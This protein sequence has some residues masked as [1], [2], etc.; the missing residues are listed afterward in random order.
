VLASR[1]IRLDTENTRLAQLLTDLGCPPESGQEGKTEKKPDV[2]S[3][4]TAPNR[5][6]LL[7]YLTNLDDPVHA[8]E[9]AAALLRFGPQITDMLIPLLYQGPHNR[10]AWIAVLLY[11]LNDPR[12]TKPLSDLLETSETGLREL[13]WDIRLRFREWRRSTVSSSVA[14]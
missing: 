13:I 7:T 4:S 9:A 14:Q 5:S 10:R 8:M 6:D 2:I 12:A 11:E 3:S 1:I